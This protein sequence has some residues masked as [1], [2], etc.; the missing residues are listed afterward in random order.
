MTEFSQGI[1]KCMCCFLTLCH[2]NKI[3]CILLDSNLFLML[4]AETPDINDY[5][6][7]SPGSAEVL[8]RRLWGVGGDRHGHGKECRSGT[9]LRRGDE[10]VRVGWA[11]TPPR[12]GHHIVSGLPP[13]A[14]FPHDLVVF[15]FASW[16]STMPVI[17]CPH[18]LKKLYKIKMWIIKF[19]PFLQRLCLWDVVKIGYGVYREF[20]VQ[21]HLRK[22]KRIL[23]SDMVRLGA[24]SFRKHTSRNDIFKDV[25]RNRF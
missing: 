11:V 3:V 23:F 25:E 8:M 18:M 5:W 22:L 15:L 10:R 13:S 1:A 20:V 24:L 7:L 2:R 17:F 9:G 14:S 21:E 16:V 6:E 19:P 12:A 4:C